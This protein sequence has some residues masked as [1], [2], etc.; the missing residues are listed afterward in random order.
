MHFHYPDIAAV[1]EV[2][3]IITEALRGGDISADKVTFACYTGIGF[4][5]SVYPGEPAS[6]LEGVAG[7][8]SLSRADAADLLE[9][10]CGLKGGTES[11]GAGL[12]AIP[13]NLLIPVLMQLLQEWLLKKLPA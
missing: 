9:S 13:W 3:P 6:G 1:Q 12:G 4:G 2:A 11:A 5:L 7:K 10:A 8:E